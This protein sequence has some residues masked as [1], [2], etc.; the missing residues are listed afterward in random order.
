MIERI[1]NFFHKYEK[2]SKSYLTADFSPRKYY[3]WTNS[4]ASYVL[5]DSA[6]LKTL[7]EFI[8]VDELLLS[9]GLSAPEI[10]EKD[11]EHGFL[12][13]EDFGDNTFTKVLQNNSSSEYMLYKNAVQTL[14]HLQEHCEN[15]PRF[16]KEYTIQI[17]LEKVK[18]FSTHYLP[19]V[20][21]NDCSHLE[22]SFLN[23]WQFPIQLAL[24]TK[25]GIFLRDYHV[26][27]LMDLPKRVMPKSV[28]LLD[29]QDALW[30]PVAGDLVSLLEDARRDVP[31]EI[32]QDMWKRYLD[33][34]PKGD[35]QEI[36]IAGTILSA[37]R[38]AKIIGLFTR[39][40]KQ[41]NNTRHL[42]RITNLWV[43]LQECCKISELQTVREWLNEYVPENL[44]IVPGFVI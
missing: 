2:F 38:H 33:F 42:N 17:G 26:D 7:N 23:A 18:Q 43:L 15:K 27:N 6:D 22:S 21:A 24:S 28:G 1:P 31:S 35:H 29:F 44:R 8:M 39:V 19:Q 11:T 16:L 32:K 4:N 30:A 14:I 37:V 36:Y 3:R 34:Y 20:L 40:A 5:M 41:N 9:M 12:L 25:K 13:L 10:V